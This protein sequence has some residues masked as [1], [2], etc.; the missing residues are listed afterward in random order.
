MSTDAPDPTPPAVLPVPP[1]EGL[2]RL[3]ESYG[4]VDG[5]TP[6]GLDDV[7][8][9]ARLSTRAAGVEIVVRAQVVVASGDLDAPVSE[10]AALV[11][12]AGV[13]F[14]ELRLR[15]AGRVD[16]A[17]LGQITRSIAAVCDLQAARDRVFDLE[18]AQARSESEFAQASGQIV[19]DLNNPLAAVSMCL[20]IAREQVP[21]GELLASLLDRAS[22]SAHKMKRMV[23]SLSDY[24]QRTVPG[25]TDL[26]EEVPA[27]LAEYSPLLDETVVVSGELPTVEVSPGDMRT[28]LT[29]LWENS[30]K[31]APEDAG[32]EIE[33]GAEPS[34]I[35]WRVWVSDNGR[36][37]DPSDAERIFTPTVRLD[38]RVSGM[39][40]GLSAVRRIITAAG[41][42]VGAEALPSRGARVWFDVPMS[43]P[44]EHR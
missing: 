9:L 12:E 29:A 14:G 27:L 1:D 2:E 13:T 11:G 8:E 36:G 32:L 6:A 39:G 35:G 22:N 7:C 23:V 17:I 38:K 20:E 41:G 31:F 30:V 28:V 37:F 16:V 10:T 26:A 19:H 24:G 44:P 43:V 42:A 5:S 4:F 33:V 3:L 18:E 34:A 25:S 40:L 21:D 15:D